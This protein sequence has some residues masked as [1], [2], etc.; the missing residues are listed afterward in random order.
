MR[1]GENGVIR[2]QR[3]FFIKLKALIMKKF[4]LILIAS[5][6]ICFYLSAQSSGDYRSVSSGNWNE[7][8]AWELFDGA[9]WVSATTYPGQNPGT[10]AVTITAFHWIRLTATVP[11]PVANIWIQHY[12]DEYWIYEDSYGIL[13][14]SA[15]N[16][17]SL[18]VLGTINNTGQ[19]LLV[20]DQPGTKTHKL[21]IGGSL[22][23]T[24]NGV[25]LD[26]NIDV[27]FNSILPVSFIAGGTFQNVTFNGS[28]FSVQGTMYIHGNISFMNGIVN[29][30]DYEIGNP[31]ENIIRFGKGATWTGASTISYIDGWVGKEGD[32]PFTFPV[33]ENGIYAPLTISA[34]VQSEIFFARYNRASGSGLG[35]ITDPG[36]FNVSQCEYWDLMPGNGQ[37]TNSYPLSITVGWNSSSGCGT[38]PYI[39]DVSNVT[40]AHFD[41]TTWNSHG[42]TA[43]GTTENG[44]VTWSGVTTFSPFT[45]GN[46]GTCMTPSGLNTTNI[47][48]SSATVSWSPEPGA[49]SYNVYYNDNAYGP[50]SAWQNA[51]IGT[52]L[53][54][55]NL[56]GLNQATKYYYRIRA[57]CS[58]GTSSDRQSEFTTL[59]VCQ[60]PAW[61]A[62]NNITNASVTLNWA[63]VPGA[64]S[65]HVEY[66]HWS[67]WTPVNTVITT[68]S[69]LLSG[70][71]SGSYYNFQVR[72]NCPL[73]SSHYQYIR[74][75]WVHNSYCEQP[76]SLTTTNI[77]NNSATLNWATV[78]NASNYNV[79]YKQSTSATWIRAATG[80]TS[81]YYILNGLPAST[82]YDWRV[83]AIC[84]T[85]V[86]GNY[87]QSTFTTAQVPPPISCND[88]YEVNN[89]SRQAKTIGLGS[90]VSAMISS[91]ADIDWFKITAPN[92]SNYTLQVTL[93]NLPADYDLYVYDK[94]LTQVGGST[95]TGTSNEIVTYNSNARKATYY[96]KVLGK[97]GAYNTSQCYN[98]LA[99]VSNSPNSA[100]SK[101]YPTNEVT[102]ISEKQS[103][104]PNPASEF[105]Y[106]NFN[107]ATEAVVNIQIINS[108]GQLVKQLPVNILNGHNQFKV[109]L[110]DIRPGMYI[111]RINKGDL[112]ITR[113]FVIAR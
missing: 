89:T 110:A 82:G 103:L 90:T 87:T 37:Y 23:G 102:E 73:G 51:A 70:L 16:S 76:N 33:G 75:I 104:Y 62:A 20:E 17:V 93:A 49:A 29:T 72:A 54:S 34:P 86:P 100:S 108:I 5:I 113:K 4:I 19:P 56:S 46:I 111:I 98:L 26:D 27:I 74:D 57:N 101:S 30:A 67:V 48:G 97:N 71:M 63:A 58:S 92:N 15:E 81:P 21:F 68:T 11:H 18:T 31:P 2:N 41:R 45:F 43:T 38:S 106:L 65:Y 61:L 91:S 83:M 44:S 112:N 25:N 13:I 64:T 55:V 60:Q 39:A 42:G 95:N 7:P 59:T 79:E 24:L 105:V 109:Q 99:Q 28:V 84:F 80:I 94:N 36:L 40:L 78:T 69:Y 22:Y 53:T 66:E 10:G 6:G 1:P 47:T 77:T 9:N 107:S 50:T 35:A 12:V 3:W 88:T 32:E 52:T 85:S 96:I 14:F 8:A